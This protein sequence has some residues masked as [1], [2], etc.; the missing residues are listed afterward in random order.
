M[1]PIAFLA[2]RR[3][4]AEHM[5]P[6]WLALP[7]E[8]RGPFMV[9]DDAS[10]AAVERTGV[11]PTRLPVR[12]PQRIKLP[13][14]DTVVVAGYRD[15]LSVNGKAQRIALMTHG[16]GQSYAGRHDGAG[17]WIGSPGGLDRGP[18]GMFLH[19]GPHPAARDR[20]RYPRA[21]IEV[22]GSPMLDRL[23]RK[24][25]SGRDPVI[26]VTTHWDPQFL[27]GQRGWQACPETHSALLC[28]HFGGWFG[29]LD[30]IAELA[31]R[32]HVIGHGH[33]GAH[34]GNI[35]DMSLVWEGM[36]IEVVRDFD[37]VCR[38]ADLLVADNSSVIY[39]FAATGRPV[40]LLDPPWYD[41]NVGHGLRFWSASHVGLHV[42]DPRALADT[43]AEALV[44]NGRHWREREDALDMVFGYREHA[45]ERAAVALLDWVDERRMA[46]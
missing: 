30:A 41:R 43:V 16:I 10:A 23:H 14:L 3:H 12:S 45:A 40:V 22:V 17:D 42:S 11:T 25:R 35:D 33:P 39:E 28:S 26:A 32:Y 2:R 18:V 38:K 7:E 34:T 15:L 36:G 8:A 13:P 6:V 31:K 46:A 1:T 9:L 5:A 4:L 37:E 19:P 29:V 44:D 24:P 27:P 20:E 21:R